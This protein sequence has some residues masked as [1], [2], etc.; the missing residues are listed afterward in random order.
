MREIKFRAWSEKENKYIY[1]E[2]CLIELLTSDEMDFISKAE[3]E[4]YTGLKDK[5]GKE[6]YEGDICTLF[7]DRPTVVIFKNGSFG[8]N[9]TGDFISF[10][11]NHHFIFDKDGK[12]EKIKIIGNINKNPE[13]LESLKC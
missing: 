1:F 3:S 12:S 6:I 9:C 13:L 4:Q 8:Y 10:A 5:N 2:L 11:Q 7:T